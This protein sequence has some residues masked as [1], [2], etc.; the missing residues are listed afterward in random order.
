M[1]YC[2]CQ[3]LSNSFFYKLNNVAVYFLSSNIIYKIII[4]K[5]FIMNPIHFK[6]IIIERFFHLQFV[7]KMLI[8][9][10]IFELSEN[11]LCFL[12]PK[13]FTLICS[14]FKFNSLDTLF[15]TKLISSLFGN[16]QFKNKK[17]FHF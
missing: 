9:F 4:I 2:L 5:P 14:F 16:L 17:Q 1:S 7:K 3:A 11:V 8:T 13:K 10:S 6:L 15:L 12:I